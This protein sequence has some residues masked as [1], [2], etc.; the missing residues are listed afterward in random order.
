MPRA[1]VVIGTTVLSRMAVTTDSM[2]SVAWTVQ[3]GSICERA[4]ADGPVDALGRTVCAMAG[5]LPSAPNAPTPC[6]RRRRLRRLRGRADPGR[7]PL[8]RLDAV[9]RRRAVR[10][11]HRRGGRLH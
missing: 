9:R 8:H 1:M 10:A 2:V 11:G 7:V 6:R 3:S 4:G 5:T